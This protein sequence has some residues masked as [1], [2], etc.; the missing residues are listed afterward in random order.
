LLRHVLRD[1]AMRRA[2]KRHRDR[3]VM[4]HAASAAA[5]GSQPKR[6]SLILAGDTMVNAMDRIAPSVRSLYRAD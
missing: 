6:R 4:R 5:I 2:K 3:S 1:S